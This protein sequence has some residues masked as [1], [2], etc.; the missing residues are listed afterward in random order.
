MRPAWEQSRT[1]AEA[2]LLKGA[3]AIVEK[4]LQRE[5]KGANRMYK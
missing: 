1:N 4:V 3:E 5:L 2:I